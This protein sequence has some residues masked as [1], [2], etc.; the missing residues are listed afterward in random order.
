MIARD[1]V[2]QLL[3]ELVPKSPTS[4]EL[5]ALL[6]WPRDKVSCAL[7][8]L[9]QLGLAICDRRTSWRL[10]GVDYLPAE[11]PSRHFGM[12]ARKRSDV[13]SH[14]VALRGAETLAAM[15]LVARQRLLES[16]PCLT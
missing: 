10:L 1:R 3:Q 7:F 2:H 15:Q 9:R 14:R 12:H 4:V 8:D 13:S 5:A 6:D 16:A 11:P